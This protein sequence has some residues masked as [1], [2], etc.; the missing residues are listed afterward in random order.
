[1]ANIFKN[2]RNII[3]SHVFYNEVVGTV[4]IGHGRY[5]TIGW[6]SFP[7][8]QFHIVT[9]KQSWA[10]INREQNYL[11]PIPDDGISQRNF[12]AVSLGSKIFVVGGQAALTKKESDK[13]H[14]IDFSGVFSYEQAKAKQWKVLT[15]LKFAIMKAT[16]QIVDDKLW[17]EGVGKQ[18][19][20]LASLRDRGPTIQVCSIDG[21]NCEVKKNLIKLRSLN[22]GL[23][24]PIS[25]K[26]S[27]SIHYIGGGQA[28]RKC[29]EQIITVQ[30]PS[31]STC[32]SRTE[33][34]G[35]EFD[36]YHD[37]YAFAN[38]QF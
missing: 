2:F 38:I 30:E 33:F 31:T 18:W 19:D 12:G 1:M 4:S 5:T 34:S 26:L 14:L 10:T 7:E 37:P 3:L 27:D 23:E 22:T 21:I 28:D 24:F 32:R 35:M 15:S 17:I 11:T 36:P 6:G 8:N 9:K 20:M 29:V 13:I 16:I 25:Y